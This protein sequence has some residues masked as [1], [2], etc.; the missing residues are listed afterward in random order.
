MEINL[1]YFLARQRNSVFTFDGWAKD[2]ESARLMLCLDGN[3]ELDITMIGSDGNIPDVQVEE[4]VVFERKP[5]IILE[6][7]PGQTHVFILGQK[8]YVN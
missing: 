5:T 6:P 4:G 2:A 3:K 7:N 8:F 1:R